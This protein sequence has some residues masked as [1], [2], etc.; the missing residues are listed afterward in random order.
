[1]DWICGMQNAINY[2]EE[3]LTDEIDIED[4]ARRSFSSAY[5]FQ[6]VFSLLCGYT[7]GEYIR[8]RRLTLA[9]AE[10]AKGGIKVIDAALKYGYESPDSFAKAFQ[11]FHGI[12]P[13]EARTHGKMLKAFS[14]LSIKISLEGG[15]TMNYRIEEKPEFI[16]TG[17][18]RHFTGFPGERAAQEE[19]MYVST[20]PFQCILQG[21]SGDVETTYDVISNVDD[22]GYDFWITSKLSEFDRNNLSSNS[23]LG[24]EFAAYFENITIPASTFAVFETER[25]RYPTLTFLELRR[26]IAS[27]WLPTSGYQ[28][29]DSP[30]IVVSHWYRGERR[31]ERY[32]E[33]WIPVVKASAVNCEVFP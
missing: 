15:N 1:M 17:Y 10:L 2:I 29:A 28:L 22:D 33:L 5:H 4:I 6:R 23:V 30:E 18:K 7:L 8:L 16:L 26:R 27:E 24:A 3:H 32:R 31:D 12:L 11:K 9:G 20:R 14:R 25:C 19:E 21:L 13:S